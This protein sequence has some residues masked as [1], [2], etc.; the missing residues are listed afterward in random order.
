M[1]VTTWGELHVGDEVLGRDGHPWR[2]LSREAV[3]DRWLAA[4]TGGAHDMFELQSVESGRTVKAARPLGEVLTLSTRADHTPEASACDALVG[5]GFSLTLIREGPMSEQAI[6]PCN[7]PADSR[8]ILNDGRHYCTA[9]FETTYTPDG[10][11]PERVNGKVDTVKP[12]S[13]P[14]MGVDATGIEWTI[15]D[16][17]PDA[18]SCSFGVH[19][20]EFL[21]QSD[22]ALPMTCGLCGAEPGKPVERAEP[23]H[24][25]TPIKIMDGSWWCP[26]CKETVLGPEVVTL[27]VAPPA[28]GDEPI[29]LLSDDQRTLLSDRP[30]LTLADVARIHDVPEALLSDPAPTVASVTVTEPDAFSDPAPR[31]NAASGHYEP[32]RDQWGRYKLPH[33]VTGVE[34][35]WTRATT[36]AR[37]L[38]DEYNLERWKLRQVAI[39]LATAPDLIAL[40]ASAPRDDKATLND[41]VKKAMNRAESDRGANLGTALHAFTHRRARGETIESMRVPSALIGDLEA[42]ERCMREHALTE[43]PDLVER[44]VVNTKVGAAGTFDR[45]VAQRPG[46]VNAAP[47]SVLD[48]K[49]AKSLEY[50]FL[51]IAIQLAIY[52]HADY[53]WHPPTGTYTQMPTDGTVD[54]FR[55]LVLHLPVGAAQGTLWAVNIHEGWEYAQLAERARQARNGS[56]GLGW[57]VEP[58]PETLLIHRVSKAASQADIAA[59]W[60]RHAPAGAWTDAVQAAAVERLERLAVVAP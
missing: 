25:H 50:S 37:V 49:T 3:R 20:T 2:V 18:E 39:G 5:A 19:P 29:T 53:L 6:N 31:A 41:V 47:M 27:D 12:A 55:A 36:L 58:D 32:P 44:I 8:S 35:G 34:Q 22:A 1:T 10:A 26:G 28:A 48:L 38:A 17:V 56:K 16:H 23:R 15:P 46:K 9:C 45:I 11:P 43:L 7:H 40:A 42:Y 33:P 59:L 51:E 13:N 54:L 60:D 4:G 52:A 57:L 30:A 21:V 24:E 14:R